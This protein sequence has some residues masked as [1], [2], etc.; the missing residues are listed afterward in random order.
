MRRLA[1]LLALAALGSG[2]AGCGDQASGPLDEGLGYLPKNA[3]FVVAIDTDPESGQ[4]RSLGRIIE[5]F[6]FGSQLK[7]NLQRQLEESGE[8]SFRRDVRPLLGNPF[9]VG[10]VSARSITG[11]GQ[12]TNEFVGAL[13]V[14]DKGKLESVVNKQGAKADGE[15]GDA[16]LYKDRDGD[17]FAIR[18][19]VLVVAGSRPLLESALERRGG[20]DHMDQEAF[21][22]GLEGLPKD[23]LLRAY[24]DV[25]ALIRSDP[26]SRDAQRIKWVRSLTT[27]GATAQATDEAVAVDFKLKTKD[28]LS[29]RDLPVATGDEAPGV[30]ERAG[31]IGLGVRNPSRL[32]KFGEAALQAA[33]PS[34]YGQYSAGKRQIQQRYGVNVDRDV[35]DQLKGDAAVSF[36]VDGKVATRA[37]VE[38]PAAMKRTLRKLAPALPELLAN[39][40]S[41]G[42][43]LAKPKR[44]EDF[45]ALAEPGGDSVAFGVV[46]DAL[47]VAT[48]GARAGQF[49]DDSPTTVGGA[50]GAV[51]LKA[52]A[53]QVGDRLLGRLG[54]QLGLGG[55]FGG[56]M[57]TAPLGELNGWVKADTSAMTGRLTLGV[58]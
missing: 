9:V 44:G 28:G 45:Y 51:V 33:D 3:P 21:D 25:A 47:V 19:D 6:P 52:D 54:S 22:K 36:S 23:A 37:E 13:K 50:K 8:V 55:A 31:E 56:R 5:K 20:D 30:V 16:K 38:D 42:A 41:R 58:D 26:E 48:D 46:G 10:G 11:G 2:I 12:D 4:Y 1:S 7:Q 57:F 15:S 40:G 34:G 18:D 32:A 39:S 24:A 49:A 14:K 29:E 53:E 27:L 35:I 17:S 43:R